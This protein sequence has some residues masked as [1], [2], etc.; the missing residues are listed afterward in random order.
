MLVGNDSGAV[1]VSNELGKGRVLFFNV[2]LTQAFTPYRQRGG[3]GAQAALDQ[4]FPFAKAASR[5]ARLVMLL[6][7]GTSTQ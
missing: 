6:E 3:Q 2:K 5:S 1:V 4:L 7:P